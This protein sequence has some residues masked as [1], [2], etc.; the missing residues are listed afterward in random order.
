MHV[1][2]DRWLSMIP[3]NYLIDNKKSINFHLHAGQRVVGRGSELQFHTAKAPPEAVLARQG[4][5]CTTECSASRAP[6]LP[7]PSGLQATWTA[8]AS[9]YQPSAS[10]SGWPRIRL[11]CLGIFGDAD[12]HAVRGSCAAIAH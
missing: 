1:K 12:A 10:A 2:Q 4:A 6:S 11:G 5:W 9:Q 3:L 8:A 7:Q